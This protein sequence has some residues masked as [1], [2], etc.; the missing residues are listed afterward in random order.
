MGNKIKV[1]ADIA[2]DM[3]KNIRI[4]AMNGRHPFKQY[5]YD[6]LYNA[7]WYEED[8]RKNTRKLLERL[9]AESTDPSYLHTIAPR[10]KKVISCAMAEGFSILGNSSIF[11]LESI[12]ANWRIAASPE[13]LEFAEIISRPL[14]EF[15]GLNNE[16]NEKLFQEAVKAADVNDIVTAFEPV[17]LGSGTEKVRLDSELKRLYDNIQIASKYHNI[18]KCRRLISS[19]IIRYS[20][21]EDYA[22]GD[23]DRLIEALS[24]REPGFDSDLKNT[25]AI[26][27]YFRITRSVQNG[28]IK[29]TIQGIR[30]YG[31][32]FEGDSSSRHFYD[33]DRLERILYKII[34]E[35]D[36]W[37]ELKKES[38][39]I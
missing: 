5:L 13:S 9:K 6:P 14:N 39:G 26:D 32:I 23:V 3:I 15:S 31:Y 21:T 7:G 24:K 16:K 34:S 38:R 2:E 36:L 30:K 37:Q 8:S 4:L 10:C 17:K 33:I 22:R 19:Y 29:A 1:Q 27:L 20:D 12:Q 18:P 11:F 35:K 25:I 28:D